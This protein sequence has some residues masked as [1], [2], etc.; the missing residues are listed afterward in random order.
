VS[1]AQL[2]ASL[3]ATLLR[4]QALTPA[5]KV[6]W[7]GDGVLQLAIERLWITAGNTAEEYRRAT[8]IAAGIDPWAQLY[9][10][11]SVLAHA[12]ADEVSADRVWA[13]SVTD[14]PGL[15]EQVRAAR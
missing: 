14:L 10:F 15:L 1:G 2:L 7:D 11:R 9:A 4:I 13:E 5:E 8:A 6:T 3:E 12:L